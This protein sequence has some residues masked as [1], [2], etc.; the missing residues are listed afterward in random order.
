MDGPIIEREGSLTIRPLSAALRD[1]TIACI[2]RIWASD[3]RIARALG[4]TADEYLPLAVRATEHAIQ[5]QLGLVL[6]DESEHHGEPT[7]AAGGGP[8][9]GFHLSTDLVDELAAQ[10]D[11]GPAESPKLQLWREM[12]LGLEETYVRRFQRR[13]QRPPKPGEVLYFNIGGIVAPLRRRGWILRMC[14]AATRELALRRGYR[15]IIA[16]ATHPDSVAMLERPLFRAVAEFEF[17]SADDARWH[18]VDEPRAAVLAE[19]DLTDALADA[20]TAPANDSAANDSAAND[21][22]ANDS[23]ANDS[24]ANDSAANDND[25]NDDDASALDPPDWS[26]LRALAHELLDRGL[27]QL[28]HIRE[29]PVWT[30][31]PDPVKRELSQPAPEAARDPRAVCDDLARLILPFPTGNIHPRFFGWVHGSGT[32]S[33]VLPAI[34]GALMNS[35]VGGRDHGALYVERCVISWCRELFGLPEAASGLLTS[36]TSMATVIALAVARHRAD[37]DIRRAGLGATA[38]TGRLV[39][40]ASSEAH[41]CVGKAFELLGLG[42]EAL[43]LIPADAD[44][45]MD[46]DA[47]RAAIAEDRAAGHRPF[48]VIAGAGTVNTGSIDDIDAIADI[49]RDDDNGLWLHVDGAF[50]ALVVLSEA[51]KPRLRGI[52]RA[53]SI[54]FDF[55]KWMHVRYDAGCVLVRDGDLHLSA[56]SSRQ[57]YLAAGPAGLAG[58]MPWPC[59]YGPELSRGF[60]ALDV[61]FT[62]QEHGT[63]RLGQAIAKNCAQARYL[64]RAIDAHPCLERM[65]PVTLAIVCFRYVAAPDAD[66]DQLNGDIVVALQQRGL[67]APSTTRL[68]G[69]LVIRVNITNHRTQRSDLDQLVGAVLAIGRELSAS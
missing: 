11:S 41:R 9:L 19:L 34:A 17:A 21:S 60:R 69:P 39:G 35:N 55:H 42:S 26:A 58:G 24:A 1:Q 61:W 2:T 44:Y 46:C 68:R 38:A 27:D 10:R 33:A 22:A 15:H 30:P 47:L 29:R 65:A 7:A 16:V 40:Y 66:L 20:W 18:R 64:A 5:H 43:R 52:E 4:V 3:N 48:C 13:Y 54:G 51:L 49:A 23:A 8:V 50:G 32:A 53:D 25:N 12:L 56:F 59:D 45:R 31:V 67:A 62:L 37:R 36:G 14:A 57:D 63:R 28:E 6:V